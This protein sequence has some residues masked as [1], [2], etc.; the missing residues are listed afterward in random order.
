MRPSAAIRWAWRPRRS[1]IFSGPHLLS[2]AE[3]ATLAVL[4]NAPAL[5]FPG[6]NDALLLAKRN[7]LL[8]TLFRRGVIDT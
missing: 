2:W 6:K 8:E 3:S 5:I 4:P 7:R 1:V